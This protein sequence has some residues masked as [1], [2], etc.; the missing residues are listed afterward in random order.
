VSQPAAVVALAPFFLGV[1]VWLSL[2]KCG[3]RGGRLNFGAL[4]IFKRLFGRLIASSSVSVNDTSEAND[5]LSLGSQS[6]RAVAVWSS[7]LD[8]PLWKMSFSLSSELNV[9]PA[10]TLSA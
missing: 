2:A 9:S 1:I 5:S 8:R 10:S 3:G 6:F 4:W 7:W